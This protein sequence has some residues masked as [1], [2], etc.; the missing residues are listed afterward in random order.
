MPSIPIDYPIEYWYTKRFR[1]AFYTQDQPCLLSGS[2]N[3]KAPLFLGVFSSTPED[4]RENS[5][6][7]FVSA[8]T[9]QQYKDFTWKLDSSNRKWLVPAFD[10]GSKIEILWL[11]SHRFMSKDLIETTGNYIHATYSS[12]YANTFELERI[13]GCGNHK[14][15]ISLADNKFGGAGQVGWKMTPEKPSQ[16]S[17]S[18]AWQRDED[19]YY[20][21]ARKCDDAEEV[22]QNAHYGKPR[23]VWRLEPVP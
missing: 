2:Y 18:K 4:V 19:S 23:H 10:S 12:G 22:Q 7:W 20:V 1:L 14:Y 13:K 5:F 6:T 16:Q 11:A 8:G 15:T 3:G 17:Y 21:H 9:S